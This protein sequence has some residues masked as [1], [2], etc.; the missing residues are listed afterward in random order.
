MY[1]EN[2]KSSGK[3]PLLSSW[4]ISVRRCKITKKK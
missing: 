2:G 1:I 4:Q 3:I